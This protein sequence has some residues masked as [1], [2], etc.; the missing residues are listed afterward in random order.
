L[1]G[2]LGPLEWVLNTPSHHRVHH[3]QNPQYID[4]NHAG[5]LI[6]WDKMFGT[7]EPEGEEV[8][9]GVTE[10]PNSWNPIFANFHHWALTWRR[11][12]AASNW[13]DKLRVWVDRPGYVPP[14]MVDT[15]KREDP[16]SK[17]ET[18]VVKPLL[19]YVSV[20]FAFLTAAT[21]AYLFYRRLVEPA[22]L[23]AWGIAI[24]LT[25]GSLGALLDHRKWVRPLETFRPAVV[26][27]VFALLLP[28]Q[29]L[30]AGPLAL[31]AALSVLSGWGLHRALAVQDAHAASETAYGGEVGEL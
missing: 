21:T 2:R 25:A 22:P 19:I 28:E 3:G 8:V 30:S 29:L 11:M 17:Y 31:L 1:I 9:Y 26:S 20:Q 12:E 18:T 4:R 13:R 6:I 10:P 24:I 16:M 15:A 7:F 5:T 14:G 27:A 23:M